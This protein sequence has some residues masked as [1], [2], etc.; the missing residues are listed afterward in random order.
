MQMLMLELVEQELL[1][2]EDLE[3]VVLTMDLQ[4][5]QLQTKVVQVVQ[6]LHT[7]FIHTVPEEEPEIQEVL[8]YL[9]VEPV[10]MEQE[11]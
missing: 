9:T 1:I 4:Q 8:E 11:A 5:P 2:L 3:L 7:H 10:A 6:E